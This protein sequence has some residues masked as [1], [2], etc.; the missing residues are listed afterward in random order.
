V[1]HPTADATVGAA[2]AMFA[3]ATFFARIGLWGGYYSP[4]DAA[5]WPK[6]AL[7][8]LATAVLVVILMQTV[9]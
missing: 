8:G 6:A 4:R 7:V 9:V 3:V 5:S 1:A 2:I